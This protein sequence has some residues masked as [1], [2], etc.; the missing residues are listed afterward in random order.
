MDVTVIL[1]SL[2]PDEKLLTVV[3]G[4]ISEGF[5]SIVII[6]DGSDSQ[7]QAPFV[8]AEKRGCTVLRHPLNRGKGCALKTG[9]HHFL[10]EEPSDVGVV[11]ADGDGQHLPAD[12]RR[13]AEALEQNPHQVVLGVRDFSSPDI[14]P[15]SRMGN[16]LTSFIFKTACG[17]SISD[18]QTGLRAIGREYLEAFVQIPGDRFEYETQMLLELRSQ[19]IPYAQLPIQTVYEDENKRSHFNPVLDSLRIYRLLFKFVA[20]SVLSFVV[21]MLA[22]SLFCSLLR[23]LPLSQLLLYSTLFARILSSVVNYL[24]NRRSV[25][26]D[27]GD[28]KSSLLRYYGLCVV[29][30]LASY[31]LVYLLALVFGSGCKIPAKMLVDCVLFFISFAIQRDW[32][33]RKGNK[34]SHADTTPPTTIL[35]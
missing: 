26:H 15:R 3:S 13:C 19:S 22:F 31:G 32:V 4:L 12:I 33:F 30:M 35:S 9:F 28:V 24:L 25:F 29:Q 34:P 16:R 27:K 1:P 21:D 17:L 20:A 7:H 10:Q 23:A 11:T 2:N 6:D 14:P 5:S 8:E 18:T